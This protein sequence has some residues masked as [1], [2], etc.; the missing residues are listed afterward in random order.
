M[1]DQLRRAEAFR[2]QHL[3]GDL[4]LPNCWDAASA[5]VF[6][7]AGFSAVAT[8]SA[9]VAWARGARDGEGLDREAMMREIA[10]IARSLDLPLNADVE[11]GYGASTTDAAET[12]RQA[13]AAGAVGINFEDADYAAPGE[14]TTISAQQARIA[15]IREAAPDLVINARTDVFLLGLGDDEDHRIHM[16]IERGRAWLDAGADVVFLPGTTDRAI[17]RRLADGIRGPISLMAGP[18]APTA[19][20]LFEAGACRISTGPYPMQAMLERLKTLADGLVDDWAVMKPAG[21]GLTK[22]GSVFG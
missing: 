4:V 1:T 2:N 3:H 9:G 14:L 20:T 16:A 5:R 15:A 6:Q 7:T 19:K 13:W 21:D 22:I 17:V 12:A 18:D 11:A 10:T 8:T